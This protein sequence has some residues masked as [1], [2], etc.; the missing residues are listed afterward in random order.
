MLFY[1]FV[2]EKHTK[3]YNVGDSGA[4]IAKRIDDSSSFEIAPL[5]YDHTLDKEEEVD[6]ILQR[7]GKVC[8]KSIIDDTNG[9]NDKYPIIQEGPLRVWYRCTNIHNRNSM[10]GLAM[11]RSLGDAG[12]HKVGVSCEPYKFSKSLTKDDEFIVLASDGIW[13]VISFEDAA[14]MVNDY[15]T[16]LP[17]IQS[18]AE[19]D[20]QEAANI[21]VTRARRKWSGAT[22][23]DDITCVVIKLK[24]ENDDPCFISESI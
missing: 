4:M 14:S 6:R 7:G 2:N 23:I 10:M 9:N 12:A 21:L 13:D 20:P 1:F 8:S 11:T 3:V 22:H 18:K 15:I 5:T 17:P 16:S 19:W 24:Q